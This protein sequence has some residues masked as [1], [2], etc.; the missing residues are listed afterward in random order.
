MDLN[1][2]DSLLTILV[3]ASI[4]ILIFSIPFAII[5]YLIKNPI[6]HISKTVV[7]A[8]YRIID[9]EMRA[10]T[11]IML[12]NGDILSKRIETSGTLIKQSKVVYKRV[13]SSAVARETAGESVT[14]IDLDSTAMNVARWL[15][16]SHNTAR[17]DNSKHQHGPGGKQLLT[18]DECLALNVFGSPREWQSARDWM[19]KQW[20]ISE[21]TGTANAGTFTDKPLSEM[22]NILTALPNRKH[23]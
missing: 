14:E 9:N 3:Y 15:I 16:A 20:L 11:E 12:P 19:R 13:Y 22:L 18:Q 5:I 10:H 23:D 17:C 7:D 8:R 6:E 2:G 21:H 4:A 1:F